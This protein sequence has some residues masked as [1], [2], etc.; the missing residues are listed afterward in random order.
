MDKIRLDDMTIQDVQKMY[1]RMFDGI[2][3][4][5]E[6]DK[7]YKEYEIKYNE[8]KTAEQNNYSA[9][10]AMGR[11]YNYLKNMLYGW[12]IEDLFYILI[13]KNPL[14]EK[15]E[16]TGN[17]SEHLFIYNHE[18]KKVSI[19]GAKTT[20]PDYLITMKN[21]KKVYLELKTAAA[22]VFSIKI[23]N[24][25]QLQKTMGSTNIY[26]MIIMI[27]LVNE[28]YEIKDMQFFINSFPFVNQRMEGQLCYDFP[29]PSK[30]F[31]EITKEDFS[32]YINEEMFLIE[33]VKKYRCLY[34]AEKTN[35]KW[36]KKEINNKIKLDELHS[37]F[38]YQE[39]EYKKKVN[40]LIEKTPDIESK[41]WDDILNSL[42]EN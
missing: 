30:K 13:K 2:I 38:I 6:L 12:Y 21:G 20:I 42:S 9:P 24:V 31:S 8:M 29:A 40:S 41:S 4:K 5:S 3:E 26:S 33:D 28:L 14:V 32:K 39:S 7:V 27:D 34:L 22:Q 35:N 17:D 37:Q 1:N 36:L 19:A 15:I 25:N 11:K 16:M 18:L 23:G 10:S